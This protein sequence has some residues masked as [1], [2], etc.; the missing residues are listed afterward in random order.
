MKFISGRGSK[1]SGWATRRLAVAMIFAGLVVT[2][3]FEEAKARA[4]HGGIAS[5]GGGTGVAL[6]PWTITNNTGGAMTNVPIE[7]GLPLGDGVFADTSAIRV[8]DSDGTT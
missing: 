2:H 7:V 4:V 3:G 5:G 1:P 6:V 8:L